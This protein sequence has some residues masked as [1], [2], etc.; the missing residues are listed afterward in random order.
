MIGM[1]AA[2]GGPGKV[3]LRLKVH[4]PASAMYMKHMYR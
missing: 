2:R 4:Y 1:L 3:V